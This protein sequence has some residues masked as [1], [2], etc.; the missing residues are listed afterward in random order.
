MA[1]NMLIAPGSQATTSTGL[2]YLLGEDNDTTR[3]PYKEGEMVLPK[4]KP[5]SAKTKE[6]LKKV[7]SQA[8]ANTLTAETRQMLIEELKEKLRN[9]N[10]QADGGRTGYKIGDIVKAQGS[11][12]IS[13]KQQI[14]G[15]PKGITSNK[16]FI[17]LIID[18]D[19]P[20]TEKFSILGEVN[21]N[22]FRDR[23]EK[24]GEEL[25]LEDPASYVDRKVGIGFN[26]G[27]EGFSGSAKYGI[28]S[29]EPE[30]SVNW[31]KS[32]AE[33]GVAGLL[34][35]S[36]RS[37]DHGPRNFNG[38]R[39]G[40]AEGDTPSQAWMRDNFYKSGYDDSGVI[41]LD[42]YLNGGQGWR[43]YMDH[44]PGKAN[45]GRIGYEK[46]G[47]VDKIGSMVDSRAWPH[48]AANTAEGVTN[49]AE[50][51]GRL[52]LAGSKLA[53][54]MIKKPLFKTPKDYERK[55]N[56]EGVVDDMEIPGVV[57]GGA[58]FVGGEMFE[59]FGDNMETGALAKKLG[60]T[61]LVDKTGK[62]LSPE[63][64][65]VGELSNLG[66]EFA[67]LG[68]IFA[69]GKNLFKG[70]DSLKKLSK[71]LGK[72]K[73]GKTLE[74]LVDE[75]LTAN[76]EGR[77]DFNKLVA[78]G[79]LMV[80]LQSIGLGGIKAAKTKA[81]PDAV[82]TLKTLIDDSDEM[83]ENG[84]MAVGRQGSV[85][86]VS[87]LTDAVK[88]S[89]AVI[90]KN[91]RNQLGEKVLKNKVKGKGGKF[92]DDYEDIPTEEAAYIMEELQKKGHNVKFEHLD[93][94]GGQGVDDILYKYKNDS[95][96]KDT[97]LG[98]ENY[99][100]FAKKVA[101]MTDKE[102]FA[103]H[104]SITDDGGQY[105]DEF[106]EELLDM[107]FKNSNKSKKILKGSDSSQ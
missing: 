99:D 82:L 14:Q 18:A 20:L 32:F 7:M 36:P 26:Q 61:A 24:D 95:L 5:E 93:D 79:G 69:A 40:L 16:S 8:G 22:K 70:A 86:D 15:A 21:Y 27:N 23:I 71:S 48:Y 37:T 38:G 31:K 42:N 47:V 104:S 68:G 103:Y 41:T 76:G 33:G 1:R 49:I 19:I 50:W 55:L 12:S 9:E 84:L 51:M 35:E 87:G 91:S 74:K 10:S 90:M 72:V 39:I 80:A 105:Y 46:A 78:S 102:K 53:S 62:N 98:K 94:M 43:D 66:G 85:I 3:V 45:G 44:G 52:P 73:E 97:K 88:K 25:F 100:K 17:S 11:G 75:T 92:T 96:Y 106:V 67:N 59:E 65:T 57:D 34:G 60:I 107:N 28:D 54:D 29:G 77:R 30:Y 56:Y 2:N 6:L 64:R 4:A 101:K 13:G 63:A 89:L 83:T 81:A 58:K